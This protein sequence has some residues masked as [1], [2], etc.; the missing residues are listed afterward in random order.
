M[1]T[2]QLA[3]VLFVVKTGYFSK[4]PLY[5]YGCF[6][7]L[8]TGGYFMMGKCG[9]GKL[10]PVSLGLALG[11][12]GAFA[13]LLWTAWIMYQG[14]PPEMANVPMPDW[15]TAFKHA[16]WALV[17]GFIFGFFLALFYV[18]FACCMA[19]MCKKSSSCGCG[20]SA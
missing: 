10:C 11:F 18:F 5:C 6:I 17:K 1:F 15:M 2:R 4:N 8:K 19:K 9:C 7:L 14:M 3:I 13:V 12:L 16:F 20:P